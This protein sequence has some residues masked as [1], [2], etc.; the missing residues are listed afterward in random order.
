[1]SQVIRKKMKDNITDFTVAFK[2]NKENKSDE[3]MLDCDYS[4][5]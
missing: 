5:L 1:M 2:V 3:V 4:S